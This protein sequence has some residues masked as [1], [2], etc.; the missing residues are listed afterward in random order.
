MKKDIILYT[1]M[2]LVFG[3][4]S[5]LI[6][7][8]RESTKITYSFTIDVNPSIKVNVDKD[9][10]IVNIK[11]LNQNAKDLFDEDNFKGESLGKAIKVISN[12]LLN[13]KYLKDKDIIVLFGIDNKSKEKKVTDLLNEFLSSDDYKYE[14]IIPEIRNEANKYSVRY[15]IT[16]AK[17]SYIISLI[18]DNNKLKLA[19]LVNKPVDEL[20]D[21][22][23]TGLYCDAEYNLKG[24]ICAKKI[25]EALSIEK[26]LCPEGYDEVNDVCYRSEN[27]TV[28]YSCDEGYTLDDNK[29]LKDE[30]KVDANVIRSCPTNYEL[31]ENLICINYS[32]KTESEYRKVCKDD[33]SELNDDVCI[34]YEVK[35]PYKKG[36]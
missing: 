30:E 31:Y 32:D 36:E 14:L 24:D 35:D 33:N 29:C 17:A 1:L 34:Q 3:F 19:D 9:D 5:I 4:L 12:K 27:V 11:L 2:I 20:Y 23:K 21:M 26:K 7:N 6:Y 10:K 22:L 15:K 13:S 28:E 18:E 25:G 16:E 8:N